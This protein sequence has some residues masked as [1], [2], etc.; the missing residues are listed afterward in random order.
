VASRPGPLLR[1]LLRLPA[2][3]YRVGGGWLL[4]HRFLL[5]TH[6]GRRTGRLHQTVLEVVSWRPERSEAVVMSGWGPHAEW[7]RNVRA[8]GAV[9]ISIARRRFHPSVR[10]LPV[11][12]A[13]AVLVD[14]E[15]RNR[16]LAPV[17]RAILSRL[18][19]FRYDGSEAGRRRLVEA[20]P[21]VAF[22]LAD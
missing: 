9:E 22:R 7:Y 10:P 12:E 19:G 6:R 21:L 4:G 14:Y 16:P 17:V 8:G 2:A 18:A 15:R 13:V 5:L 20:L 1:R 11:E 3:L